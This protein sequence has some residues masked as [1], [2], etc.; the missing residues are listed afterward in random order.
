MCQFSWFDGNKLF[1]PFF[2][3]FHPPSPSLLG[4][5]SCFALWLHVTHWWWCP[6]TRL[7][8][9]INTMPN[10][11]LHVAMVSILLHSSVCLLI[12]F[13]LRKFP[14]CTVLRQ[15]LCPQQQHLPQ[16]FP[17]LQPPQPTR[18]ANLQLCFLKT[19]SRR[20]Q[21]DSPDARGFPAEVRGSRV[22]VRAVEGALRAWGFKDTSCWPT[23]SLWWAAE[24]FYAIYK[25]SKVV[26]A[27]FLKLLKWYLHKQFSVGLNPSRR[28]FDQSKL[29]R[30]VYTGVELQCGTPET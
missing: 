12:W 21:S 28:C 18:F 7:V 24:C 8:A 29:Y 6:V 27:P 1:F 22:S 15:P 5:L 23:H 26:A 3:L 25:C 30:V 2:F 16:V 17:S 9:V 20:A 14:W 10:Y 13:S 11:L 4:M 19:N